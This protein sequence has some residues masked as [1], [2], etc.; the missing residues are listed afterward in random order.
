MQRTYYAYL[1]SKFRQVGE[2]TNQYILHLPD[3]TIRSRSDQIIRVTLTNF[4]FVN[5]IPSVSSTNNTLIV[6]G[7]SHVLQHGNYRVSD[8]QNWIN[9]IPNL[10]V[11]YS[12][13]R[14]KFVFTASNNLTINF[15]GMAP[16]F[17]FDVNHVASM[18]TGTSLASA[19]VIKIRANNEIMCHLT[20]LQSGGV[21]NVQ[22]VESSFRP[23][24]ILAVIPIDTSPNGLLCYDNVTGSFAME[25]LD[26]TI[27]SL[28]FKFT[29]T[30]GKLIENM[31]EHSITLKVEVV[32][33]PSYSIERKIDD[34][35]SLMRTLVLTKAIKYEGDV[36]LFERR[37]RIA[38][39]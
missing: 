11:V 8:L 17:G 10:S 16:L 39:S 9:G 38:Y 26:E 27:D 28:S 29:D 6:N 21:I 2:D 25:T 24:N 15:G 22:S 30:Q 7:T 20:N 19:K 35:I 36:S 1:S 34:L 12:V 37:K 32:D 14:N 33:K 3:D 18:A 13:P 5:E 23:A 4:S 31:P